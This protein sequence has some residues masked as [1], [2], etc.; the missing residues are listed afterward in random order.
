MHTSA[1]ARRTF[2][3]QESRQGI[4]PDDSLSELLELL[5]ASDMTLEEGFCAF[6]YGE[7]DGDFDPAHRMDFKT[8]RAVAVDHL[9]SRLSESAISELFHTGLD[10][11][12]DG[13]V[14]G[15]EWRQALRLNQQAIIR[16]DATHS[17][18]AVLPLQSPHITVQWN[19]EAA[20]AQ[21][22]DARDLSNLH[23]PSIQSHAPDTIS[24][25]LE[26]H[27][28]TP[29]RIEERTREEIQAYLDV[30]SCAPSKHCF[31]ACLNICCL[32]GFDAFIVI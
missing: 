26:R 23:V 12:G 3:A 24:F 20:T 11:N 6:A 8:F 2:V 17:S 31:I 15:E 5:S 7:G 1:S 4:G 9:S 14:D 10:L 28:Y 16:A 13:V 29:M 32:R 25:S 19:S 30:S 22:S 18:C 21:L 27:R